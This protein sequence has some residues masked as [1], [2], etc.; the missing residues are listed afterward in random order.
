MFFGQPIWV[1]GK[2]GNVVKMVLE[3]LRATGQDKKEIILSFPSMNGSRPRYIDQEA[4]EELPTV[5]RLLTSPGAAGNWTILQ[6]MTSKEAPKPCWESLNRPEKLLTDYS[7]HST[8][9]HDEYLRKSFEMA[10]IEFK[11]IYP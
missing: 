2:V 6:W 9:R 8:G 4:R 5:L 1:P 11:V 3:R 7:H 10:K